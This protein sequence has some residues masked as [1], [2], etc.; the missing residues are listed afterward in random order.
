MLTNHRIHKGILLFRIN[1]VSGKYLFSDTGIQRKKKIFNINGEFISLA[2]CKVRILLQKP[3][4]TKN[5]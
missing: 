5:L 1:P 2:Y 3:E 4:T